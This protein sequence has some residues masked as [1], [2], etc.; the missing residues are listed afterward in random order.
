M[1][2]FTRSPKCLFHNA[3]GPIDCDPAVESQ[4]AD[5]NKCTWS[6][7]DFYNYMNGF[8]D[9][10]AK[11]NAFSASEVRVENGHLV[12]S[13]RTQGASHDD[14]GRFFDD[15]RTGGYGNYT[16]D[17]PLLS[18]GVHSRH[19]SWNGNV[20]VEGFLQKHG[21]FEVR[22]RLPG[23]P[24][25]WPAIWMLPQGGGWPDGGEIDI[26]EAWAHRHGKVY[27]N[28]HDGV[29]DEGIKTSAG[30]EHKARS[31][32]YPQSGRSDTFEDNF[33]VYTAEWDEHE[34]KFFIDKWYVG[35]IH[36]GDF[37]ETGDRDF[38]MEV[39]T[40]ANYILLNY[41]MTAN[42]GSWAGNLIHNYRPDL[43]DFQPREM[44]IDYVRVYEKRE[45]EMSVACPW[46]G[47]FDGANC[48][49]AALPEGVAT[50]IKDGSLYS[51]A[52][53][54]APHCPQGGDYVEGAC[55][56]V[57]MTS[58]APTFTWG[59]NFYA[60]AG[61]IESTLAEGC[62]HPC[63]D[64][65]VYDG[66]GCYLGSAPEDH[67]A[68]IE[69]NNF[70]YRITHWDDF[71]GGDNLCL[72]QHP[73][74]DE[75]CLFGP[76]P[77]GRDGFVNKTNEGARLSLESFYLEPLCEPFAH[78]AN[79]AKPCPVGGRYRFGACHLMEV[80]DDA[81]GFVYDSN[82]YLSKHTDEVPCPNGGIFDGSNCLVYRM[83]AGHSGRLED[84]DFIIDA[85][86]ERVPYEAGTGY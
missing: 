84:G 15:E 75:G 35:S 25:A 62:R 29:E 48:F 60:G 71:W 50:Y 49:L 18:G 7:Y 56:H 77:Q 85:S 23:G 55:L 76:I 27:F 17:C 32:F 24:G 9:E 40:L 6:V 34:I 13:A 30:F 42:I 4:L 82:F 51:A 52:A 19:Y 11:K 59:G 67:V 54:G 14:C 1:S 2:C 78:L 83:P 65:G 69:D 22:A 5:L 16:V 36:E 21:R 66:F 38:P 70:Y 74:D 68:R 3:W 10:D 45:P 81:N 43:D 8:D 53:I 37:G 86:C 58:G 72:P 47:T 28:Y 12:L 73:E 41:T 61:N 31:R 20:S 33:H 64:I 57:T 39:P 26:M 80:P 79:C 63:G 46:G 44:L